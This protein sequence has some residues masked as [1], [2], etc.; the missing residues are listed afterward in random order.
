MIILILIFTYTIDYWI[1]SI[2]NNLLIMSDIKVFIIKLFIML[3]EIE[4]QDK[5]I[6]FSNTKQNN[7]TNIK[8]FILNCLVIIS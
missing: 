8:A 3:D 1:L 4:I 7:C 5:V 2:L 6:N